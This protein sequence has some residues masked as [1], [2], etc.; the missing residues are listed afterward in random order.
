[1]FI[2]FLHTIHDEWHFLYSRSL[3]FITALYNSRSSSLPLSKIIITDVFF[4]DLV[5]FQDSAA[6]SCVLLGSS[7]TLLSTLQ[8][9]ESNVTVNYGPGTMDIKFIQVRYCMRTQNHI[10]TR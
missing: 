7:L 2:A 9:K 1:M 5:E 4:S 6:S 3:A 10:A 8:K